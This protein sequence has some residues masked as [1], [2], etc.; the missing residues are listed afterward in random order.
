MVICVKQLAASSQGKILSIH[1]NP[2]NFLP[3]YGFDMKIL[4]VHGTIHFISKLKTNLVNL[5]FE[6]L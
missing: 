5:T 4:Q 3:F 1:L 6:C 2:R